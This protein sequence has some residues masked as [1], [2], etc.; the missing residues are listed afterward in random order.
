MV[1]PS[2]VAAKLAELAVRVSRVRQHAAPSSA[3]LAANADA[4]DL[5]AFNLMLCVQIAADI[6]S[7]LIADEGWPLARTMGEGFARLG[8]HGVLDAATADAMARAAGL[9]NVVAHGYAGVDVALVHA[10]ATQ[11]VRDLDAFA[12]QV[13]AWVAA[14]QHG[15][16]HGS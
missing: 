10:A 1:N 8:E 11:G 3:Q 6:A 13:A 15:P 9:R 4:L 5:V 2:V 12:R 7:H 16:S 14:A